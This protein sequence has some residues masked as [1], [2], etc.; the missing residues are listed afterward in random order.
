MNEDIYVAVTYICP[1]NSSFTGK[2]GDTFELLELDISKY[3]QLGNIIICG[4]FNARTNTEPDYCLDENLQKYV[5]MRYHYPADI[6]IARGNTDNNP[7]DSHGRKLLDIC[8]SSGL[9]ILNGRILGD[10][11]GY[12]TC[13]SHRMKDK[14]SLIDYILTSQNLFKNI[15]SLH[16]KNPSEHSIHCA[17]SL[18]MKMLPFNY[19]IQQEESIYEPYTKFVWKNGDGE[20]FAASLSTMEMQLQLEKLLEYKGKLDSE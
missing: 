8:K 19:A 3:E 17:L 14:P 1:N 5:N 20:K 7:V 16:V 11:L 2:A 6:A 13:F 18:H 9:R 12:A 15:S 10:T 4:D